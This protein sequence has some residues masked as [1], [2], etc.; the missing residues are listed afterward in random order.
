MA[1]AHGSQFKRIWQPFIILTLLTIAEFAIAFTMEKNGIRNWIFIVMTV[2]KAYYIV[3]FFMHLK[4][5]KVNL[6]Y[7]ILVPMLFLVYL[8]ILLFQEGTYMNNVVFG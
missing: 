6:I 4:F 5:E 8:L 2:V 7:T 1:D 3:A